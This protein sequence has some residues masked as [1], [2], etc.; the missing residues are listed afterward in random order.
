LDWLRLQK[1]FA[2]L[3]EPDAEA[4]V[5]RIQQQVEADWHDLIELCAGRCSP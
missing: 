2:H 4:T 5:D 1:R 3:L